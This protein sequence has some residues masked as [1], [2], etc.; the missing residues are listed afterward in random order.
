MYRKTKLTLLCKC[1]NIFKIIK[2][3]REYNFTSGTCASLCMS[4]NKTV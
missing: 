3:K 1:I 4:V 2:K